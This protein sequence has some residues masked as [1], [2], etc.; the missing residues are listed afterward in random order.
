MHVSGSMQWGFLRWNLLQWGQLFFVG[1][2]LLSFFFFF[3]HLPR[4]LDHLSL[5]QLHPRGLRTSSD[6]SLVEVA[7]YTDSV[8]SEL[9]SPP[10]IIE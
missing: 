4:D 8:Y 1:A 2:S 3:S 9:V 5:L 6:D 10:S 7:P